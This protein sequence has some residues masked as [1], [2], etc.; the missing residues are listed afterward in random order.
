MNRP[1]SSMKRLRRWGLTFGLPLFGGA[2]SCW[3]DAESLEGSCEV[4][5]SSILDCRASGYTD[6]LLPAG[7]VGYACTG[8]ARPDQD[9]LLN[10]GVPQGRLCADKG[11][12]DTGEEAYCCTQDVVPCAL[13]T[14]ERC[15]SGETGY[16]CWGNNRPESLNPALQCGNA[17]QERDLY[18]Y[19]CTGQPQDDP[20]QESSAVG[21]NDRLLGFL[22]EGDT[23]PRGVNYGANRSRAD[24][25]YPMC[26][27]GEEAPNPIYK[28]YCC[29]MYRPVPDGGTCV[30]HPTVPG[31][32]A[33]RFGFA[34]YGPDTPEENFE[35]FA[36]PDPGF[37]G[38]SNEGYDATLYCCDCI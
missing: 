26:S 32:E 12:L 4:V 22:C 1:S 38:E 21:C 2:I 19:C 5:S 10:D 35:S 30:P 33:G 16:Q 34:C 7:L 28:T 36:C 9:A 13:N 31:C 17:T 18:H 27:T 29:Y 3:D 8:S 23:R 37:S 20:C 6:E 25:F 11:P 24:Y 14:A 15:E